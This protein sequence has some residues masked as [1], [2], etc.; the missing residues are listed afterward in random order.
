M[1]TKL[2][3]FV[4]QAVADKDNWTEAER[5]ERLISLSMIESEYWGTRG[6]KAVEAGSDEEAQEAFAIHRTLQYS[7]HQLQRQLRTNTLIV[8]EDVPA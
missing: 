4:N 5:L 8:Q 2:E 3:Q 7:N 1:S 6:L